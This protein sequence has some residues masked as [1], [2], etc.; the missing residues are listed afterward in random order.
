MCFM[1]PSIVT[2]NFSHIAIAKFNEI[3]KRL[4]KK[5][6]RHTHLEAL[7]STNFLPT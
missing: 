1:F 7:A 4:K 2:G 5:S 6:H 3:I